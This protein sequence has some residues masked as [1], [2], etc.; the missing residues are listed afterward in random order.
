MARIIST[1]TKPIYGARITNYLTNGKNS[2]KD[3]FVGDLVSDLQYAVDGT[4]KKI[5]GKV[6]NIDV[7]FANVTGNDVNDTDSH[8]EQD[9]KIA[10]ISVDASTKN[11]SNVVTIPAREVLEYQETEEIDHVTVTP[12][13]KVEF[14]NTLSDKTTS[15]MTFELR[16]ELFGVRFIKPM[17]PDT[18]GDYKVGAF[19]YKF[20]PG[21]D[22]VEFVGLEL[23]GE[24]VE[25]VSFLQIKSAGKEGIVVDKD[26]SVTDV[27]DQLKENPGSGAVLPAMKVADP[28]TADG[29]YTLKGNKATEKANEGARCT[30][31]IAKD[32]TVFSEV[33]TYA[34]DADVTITG[35]TFT[36]KSRVDIAAAKS[37]KFVNCK[38][39]SAE[40]YQAKSY[41]IKGDG[42]GTHE[43]ATRVVIENCY[44]GTN[45]QT[46]GNAYYNL[47]ELNTKLADGTSISNNYFAKESCN[48]NAINIYDVEDGATININNNVFEYSANAV[49]IGTIGDAHCTINMNGNRYIETDSDYPDYA[50]LFLIQPYGKKTTDMSHVVIN[51][52]G[53]IADCG[54]QLYYTY[55]G[56]NDTQ[57]T[58]D[59]LPQVNVK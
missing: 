19:I 38:F 31:K 17:H 11:N 26:E 33:L 27:L 18:V 41:L 51:V 44:F 30:D 37:V 56:N 14:K 12:L 9:A 13:V 34:A 54:G 4:L 8:L 6:S 7:Y 16:Q 55:I 24:T 47:F 29:V 32:E 53:T 25:F 36:E 52:E 48:H 59:Q 46:T 22:D 2:K 23:L 57:L 43:E 3:I 42:L 49:R 5:S 50:G 40:G 10:S 58:E 1:S 39:V 45:E 28:I 20:L 21:N 15:E 35:V